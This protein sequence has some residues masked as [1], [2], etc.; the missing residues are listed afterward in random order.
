[1]DGL[2]RRMRVSPRDCRFMVWFFVRGRDQRSCETRLAAADAGFELIIND[3]SGDHV[4]T[5][6]DIAKLL[7][8]EHEV[9]AAW[10]AQGWRPNARSKR[11]PGSAS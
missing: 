7:S 10:R 9:V 8:R 1:M 2:S 4:E 6:A 3:G 5:F 11:V